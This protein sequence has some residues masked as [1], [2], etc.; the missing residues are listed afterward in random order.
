[1]RIQG[2]KKKKEENERWERMAKEARREGDVWPIVNK[3]RKRE[4]RVNEGIGM[5][6]WKEHFARLLGGIEN[7][8]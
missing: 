7:K 5:E 6:E 4:R 3:K 1:M 8:E 2:E